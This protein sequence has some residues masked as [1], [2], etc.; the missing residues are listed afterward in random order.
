MQQ[1]PQS[2]SHRKRECGGSVNFPLSKNW[3][4]GRSHLICFSALTVAQLGMVGGWASRIMN[5]P[6]DVLYPGDRLSVGSKIR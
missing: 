3:G 2:V 6:S 4:C 1:D 5:S